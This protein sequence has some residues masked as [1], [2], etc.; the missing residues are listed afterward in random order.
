[1]GCF[2]GWEE[3]QQMGD[4]RTDTGA[5]DAFLCLLLTLLPVLLQDLP[6]CLGAGRS[7][8]VMSPVKRCDSPKLDQGSGGKDRPRH[9]HPE[10]VIRHLRNA[11]CS[12]PSPMERPTIVFQAIALRVLR[13]CRKPGR[14]TAPLSSKVVVITR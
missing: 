9:Q 2:V 6:E 13:R 7:A 10:G 11:H 5:R 4:C 12:A 14:V 1:M 3:K 8:P